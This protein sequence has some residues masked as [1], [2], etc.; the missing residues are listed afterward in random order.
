ML[1][2]PLLALV[3]AFPVR[4]R[5]N[6]WVAID[7]VA[8]ALR[9]MDAKPLLITNDWQLYSPMRYTLDVEHVRPLSVGLNCSLGPDLM[10][11]FLSELAEKA[12]AAVSCYPNAGLPNPLSPTGCC[13]GWGR[14]FS[15]SRRSCA[16]RSTRRSFAAATR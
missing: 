10:Y 2:V 9:A 5:R 14:S 4:N 11:P 12:G 1:I 15:G 7:Y 6:F 3:V 13:H 16:T 8:N